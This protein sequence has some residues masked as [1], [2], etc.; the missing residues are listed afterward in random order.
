MMCEL[1]CPRCGS[2][3]VPQIYDVYPPA[4]VFKC[5]KCG[6]VTENE[7]D[8]ICID[9]KGEFKDGIKDDFALD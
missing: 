5:A 7:Y 4:Q 8:V 9:K 6:W 3:I 1:R 2:E